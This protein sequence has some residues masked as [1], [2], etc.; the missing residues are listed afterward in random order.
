MNTLKELKSALGQCNYMLR[1]KDL[2]LQCSP[3]YELPKQR[4]QSFII[5]L[6]T[7]I[8]MA[9]NRFIGHPWFR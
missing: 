2:D 8:I 5:G 4:I 9:M 3:S 6:Q 7:H 1:I